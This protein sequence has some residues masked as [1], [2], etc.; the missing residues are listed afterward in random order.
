MACCWITLSA[1]E[2]KDKMEKD[3]GQQLA[4]T[5]TWLW[6]KPLQR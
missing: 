6:C 3:A 4:G 1:Q 2:P 5:V